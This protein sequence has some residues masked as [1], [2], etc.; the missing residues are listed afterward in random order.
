MDGPPTG[1]ESFLFLDAELHRKFTCGS[2][3]AIQKTGAQLLNFFSNCIARYITI[4][5]LVAYHFHQSRALTLKNDSTL[6]E[7]RRVKIDNYRSVQTEPRHRSQKAQP[8][9]FDF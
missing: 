3:V 5:L 1:K 6:F 9:I 7:P 2:A 4:F 8:I